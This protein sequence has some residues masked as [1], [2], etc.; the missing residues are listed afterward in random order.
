MSERK[1]LTYDQLEEFA[2]VKKLKDQLSSLREFA[3]RGR[4]SLSTVSKDVSLKQQILETEIIIRTAAQF[5]MFVSSEQQQ[6][7]KE[8][9]KKLPDKEKLQKEIQKAIKESMDGY[10]KQEEQTESQKYLTTCMMLGRMN[11]V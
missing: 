2:G 5:E 9:M 6:V 10:K 11:D 3:A 1:E 4:I 7:A 8:A